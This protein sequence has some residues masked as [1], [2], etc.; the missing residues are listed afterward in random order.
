MKNPPHPG[1]LVGTNLEAL[2]V[3]M[4][5]AAKA[6]GIS[7]QRLHYVIVGRSSITPEMAVRLELALGSTAAT[8]LGM[9]M[10]YDLA[11]IQAKASSLK[12]TR[13]VPAGAM[14]TKPELSTTIIGR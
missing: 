10:T 7:R 14:A 13:L 3:S 11:R 9:R 8:W 4:K 1:E 6:L 5:D 2:G 12:V